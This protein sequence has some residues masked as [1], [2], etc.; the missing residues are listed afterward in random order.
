MR[1]LLFAGFLAVLLWGMLSPAFSAPADTLQT[2]QKSPGGAMLR[3]LVFPGW[4]QFYNEKYLKSLIVFGIEAGFAASISYQSDQV[5]RYEKKDDS[6]AAKFYR[7]DRNRLI[8]WLAGFVLLSMGDAYVDAYL[9]N[10]DISPDISV[11]LSPS[12]G[13]VVTWNAQKLWRSCRS[14]SRR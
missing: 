11:N 10:Y 4:G 13:L 5:K 12:E 6:E 1:R 8:W 14:I 3:S 7:N 2:K 9:F